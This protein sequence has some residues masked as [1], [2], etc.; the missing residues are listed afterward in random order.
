MVPSP[1]DAALSVFGDRLDQAK[2]YVSL[3]AGP[4]VERGLIGPSETARLWERHLLNCAVVAPLLPS[5]WV[6]DVGSGAGLPGIVLALVRPEVEFVLVDARR[7]RTEFLAEVVAALGLSNVVVRWAR[8]E[9]L[10]GEVAA[11]AAVSRAV[12]P[13]DRLVRWSLPLLRLQGELLALKGESAAEEVAA[14]ESDIRQSGGCDV[15]IEQCGAGVVT[16]ATVVVRVKRCRIA[17]PRRPGRR[18]A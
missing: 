3:L 14:A 15:R 13:V 10:A 12:A 4:G 7:R 11:D 18:R 8:A 1:P 2:A 5:G 17:A 9:D 6:I 16:P